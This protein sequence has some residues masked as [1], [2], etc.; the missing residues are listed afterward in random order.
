[1]PNISDII[2]ITDNTLP[3]KGTGKP[4]IFKDG[5]RITVS[6]GTYQTGRGDFGSGYA[7]MIIAAT[8]TYP[9]VLSEKTENSGIVVDLTSNSIVCSYIIK[10]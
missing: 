6:S 5:T 8:P 9:I 4:L 3:C 2:K 10:Y 1:M 7:E